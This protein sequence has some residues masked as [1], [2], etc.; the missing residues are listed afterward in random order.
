M[1]CDNQHKLPHA[2]AMFDDFLD[3]GG[4]VFDTAYIYGG[5]LPE[6]LLGHWLRN[7]GVRDEVVLIGKGAHTPYNY[8]EYC[9]LQLE[10]SLERL[11]VDCIDV[12][13]LHRDNLEVPVSEWFDALDELRNEGLIRVFGGSN[14]SLARFAEAREYGKS[15]GKQGFGILSNQFSLAEMLSPVWQGC[16][17]AN[18]PDFRQYLQSEE[19]VALFPWSSQARGF[20]TPIFDVVVDAGVPENHEM[21]R[22]WFSDENLEKRRRTVELAKHFDVGT[23]AI[24]LAY[25]LAQPFKTFP[26]IGPRL[27]WEGIQ[28]LEAIDLS[29]TEDQINWLELKD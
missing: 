25:V 23:I 4:N 1:G 24:A 5:G 3:R 21:V 22:C 11:Q 6:A 20:F 10:Q 26:L 19:E 9:R 2:A 27:L 17:S 8:P 18:S 29:L 15:Q 7:R 12:Y 14:W 13:F 28:S 16:I